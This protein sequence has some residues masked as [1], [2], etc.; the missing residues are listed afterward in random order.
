MELPVP[1]ADLAVPPQDADSRATPGHRP[2]AHHPRPRPVQ[3]P[4]RQVLRSGGTYDHA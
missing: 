4:L 1:V 3:P 2:V